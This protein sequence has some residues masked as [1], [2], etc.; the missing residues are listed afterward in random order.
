MSPPTPP[1]PTPLFDRSLRPQAE[2]DPLAGVKS[3]ETYGR[4]AALTVQMRGVAKALPKPASG[5]RK[6]ARK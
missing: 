3:L 4:L 1:D 6:G 5:R 2:P